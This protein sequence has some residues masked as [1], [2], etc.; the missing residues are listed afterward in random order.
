MMSDG[1]RD[2]ILSRLRSAPAALE[3]IPAPHWKLRQLSETE[4]IKRF[5]ELLEAVH[6]EVHTVS[7]DRWVDKVKSIVLGKGVKSLLYPPNTEIGNTLEAGWSREQGR[8]P[9]LVPYDRP[10]EELKD[11]VF[12]VDAAITSAHGGIA[13]NGSI[14]IW[15]TPDEPRLMSLVPPIH[16]ALLPVD[17][18]HDGF[19]HAV[20]KENWKAKMPA[21]VLLVSGPSKTADIEITLA[22]GIHGPRELVVLLL[23][24][25]H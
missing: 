1:C 9:S 18:I 17:K 12:E 7:Q 21:N 20:T 11:T 19:Q 22:H 2:A 16:I 23:T 24:E 25:A 13:Q 3:I 8:F 5:Q 10:I 15:C 6:T 4:K 14:V